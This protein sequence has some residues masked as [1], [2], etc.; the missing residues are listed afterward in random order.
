[1]LSIRGYHVGVWIFAIAALLCLLILPFV[2]SC[3]SKYDPELSAS[4][5]ITN[6]DWLRAL[7]F[8]PT[9]FRL[10]LIGLTASLVSLLAT[11]GS[12]KLVRKPRWQMPGLTL[13]ASLTVGVLYI[14]AFMQFP[15]S[16]TA[17]L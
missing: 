11:L 3:C 13:L 10:A 6:S 2:A 7:L 17:L 4:R 9:S 15:T 1:M 14:F 5:V 8:L 16:A 12:L